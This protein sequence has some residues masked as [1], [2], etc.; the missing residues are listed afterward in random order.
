MSMID[1]PGQEMRVGGLSFPGRF[2]F[3]H[4]AGRNYRHYIEAAGSWPS[5]LYATGKPKTRRK[6]PL[7][8]RVFGLGTFNAI[9]D[10]T[11]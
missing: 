1:L 2:R 9:D 7:A 8:Q 3:T 11:S 6:E 4:E 10:T 5:R